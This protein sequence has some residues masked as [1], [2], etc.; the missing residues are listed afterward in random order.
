MSARKTVATV[1]A[2]YDPLPNTADV[3]RDLESD[4]SQRADQEDRLNSTAANYG[5]TCNHFNSTQ[6]GGGG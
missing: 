2:A 5:N 3:P 6:R 4:L 1:V